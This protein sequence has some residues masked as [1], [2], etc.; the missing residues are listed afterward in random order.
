MS[1]RYIITRGVLLLSFMAAGHGANAAI[2]LNDTQFNNADWSVVEMRDD[3]N[4][5]TTSASQV[6]AGG[7]G[8][9]YRH[10]VNRMG[11][12]TVVRYAHM[13][14]ATY[15]PTAD[16]A[17]DSIDWSYDATILSAT[18]PSNGA[19]S[20]GILLEQNG[21]YYAAAPFLNPSITPPMQ[22]VWSSNSGTGLQAVNFFAV[23]GAGTPDFSLGA[24]AIRFGFLISNSTGQV[25]GRDVT[26]GIDNWRVRI[27]NRTGTPPPVAVAE[28]SVLA[29][30]ALG[31]LFLGL[32]R[33][34]FR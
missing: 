19:V 20:T 22:P 5:S 2:I 33:R 4:N 23:D 34:L 27:N 24:A 7:N 18:N 29:L 10:G 13:F 21:V 8:G 32:R 12:P 16:G 9:A 11:G 17:V 31:G 3:G 26:W 1:I 25:L 28:P 15:D 30:L 6:L 14:N